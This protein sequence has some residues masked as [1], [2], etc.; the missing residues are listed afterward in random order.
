MA[1]AVV[2]N[3]NDL[4][5]AM[6]RISA[7]RVTINWECYGQPFFVAC[8]SLLD[9]FHEL[10]VTEPWRIPLEEPVDF[11]FDNTTEK[12]PILESWDGYLADIAEHYP[13]QRPLYGTTPRFEDD[14]VF[15]PLQA[16]DFR[17]W[18]VRKWV[19]EV[20]PAG[21]GNAKF[22]FE[23]KPNPVP[24]LTINFPEDA[25]ATG[26]RHFIERVLAHE[27][28]STIVRDSGSADAVDPPSP[29]TRGWKATWRLVGKWM[30]GGH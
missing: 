8:R 17:A 16:A 25:L 2:L 10:R 11:Y 29:L 19:Q 7:D 18:W 6:R 21:V 22:T 9:A 12:R 5:R 23:T 27:G 24:Q 14:E 28:I 20:G 13:D 26:L 4:G 1:I 15:L 30:P 3:K